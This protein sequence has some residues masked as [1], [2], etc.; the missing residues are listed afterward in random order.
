MDIPYGQ[1]VVVHQIKQ[2]DKTRGF[3]DDAAG[4]LAVHNFHFVENIM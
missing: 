2:E 3:D 1:Y 4:R